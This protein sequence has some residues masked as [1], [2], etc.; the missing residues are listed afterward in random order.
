MIAGDGPHLGGARVRRHPNF[1][2][3]PLIQWTAPKRLEKAHYRDDS[4]CHFST[5]A[6]WDQRAEF[7][8]QLDGAAAWFIERLGDLYH[9]GGHIDRPRKQWQAINAR[10][11]PAVYELGEAHQAERIFLEEGG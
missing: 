9:E 2:C 6:D 11:M 5:T 8:Q 10:Y 3:P 1:G 7:Y 4:N